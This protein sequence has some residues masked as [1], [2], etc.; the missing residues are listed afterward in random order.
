M[1]PRPNAAPPSVWRRIFHFFAAS[2]TALLALVVPLHEYMLIIGGLALLSLAVD[3]GRLR[4][5]AMNRFLLRI[6][7]PLLK[8]AEEGEITGATYVL[9][10][11]FFAFY[12]YGAQVAIP[13]LLFL[14]VGDPVSAL[15]GMRSPGPKFWGKSPVGSVAFVAVSLIAWAILV[16]LGYGA[17]SWAIVIT[18]FIAAGVEFMPTPVDD[19]LTIPMV[20]GAHLLLMRNLGL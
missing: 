16:A 6:F 3:T 4:M 12:F 8:T 19:N 18:A 15:V 11:A 20:S 17:W 5:G 9:I 2:V 14:A 7:N 13:V 1:N 10:A